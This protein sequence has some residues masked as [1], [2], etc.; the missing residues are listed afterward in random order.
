[1]IILNGFNEAM[2]GD[3]SIAGMKRVACYDYEKMIEI[4]KQDMTEEEAIEYF[5]YNIE[6][7]Y[8]GE[9]TPAILFKYD[10]ENLIAEIVEI[11]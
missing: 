5:E 10:I 1:M 7:A 2:I 9:D 3:I 6:N 4:L 8:F 11:D